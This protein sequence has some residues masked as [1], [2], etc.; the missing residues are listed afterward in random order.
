MHTYIT[1]WKLHD[2]LQYGNSASVVAGG[3]Y[4]VGIFVMSPI[5]FRKKS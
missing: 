2:K 1:E 4:D 3:D 5:A